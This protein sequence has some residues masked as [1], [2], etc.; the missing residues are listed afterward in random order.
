LIGFF[1]EFTGHGEFARMPAGFSP[2]LLV[3][4]T[5]ETLS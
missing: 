2:V 4:Q 3:A 5:D 1:G